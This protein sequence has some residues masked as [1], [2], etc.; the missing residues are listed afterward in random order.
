[1]PRI[2]DVEVRYVESLSDELFLINKA[3][4]GEVTGEVVV[5]VDSDTIFLGSPDNT[6]SREGW[7]VRS[8]I[9]S[10]HLDWKDWGELC[11]D[12][13][14]GE[15]PYV[16]TGFVA[17]AKGVNEQLREKWIQLF[18]ILLETL[19]RNPERGPHH[20]NNVRWA[21]QM[22]FSMA[23]G[24]SGVRF[25]AMDQQEHVFGWRTVPAECDLGNTVLFH[26]GRKKLFRV[27]AEVESA[28]YVDAGYRDLREFGRFHHAASRFYCYSNRAR[29]KGKK[30][31]GALN[32]TS[33]V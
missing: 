3:Y 11:D 10:S 16:N 22:A 27:L 28:G 7:D 5:L 21:E 2:P 18:E 6:L 25:N 9:E 4:V 19:K 33:R 26:T 14:I 8:R 20:G 15:V 32:G 31:L 13:G 29:I 1:V 23:L 24:K 12:M 30:L 17:F